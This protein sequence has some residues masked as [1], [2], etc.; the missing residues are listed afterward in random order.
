MDIKNVKKNLNRKV[1]Y[2]DSYGKKS[3]Y[4]L[5]ACI[6]KK[7]KKTNKYYYL[8]ELQDLKVNSVMI[9]GLDDID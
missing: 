8:A 5:T 9:V 6:L 3:E 1:Q 2:T 7:N 4:I